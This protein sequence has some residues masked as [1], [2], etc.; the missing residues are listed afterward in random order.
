MMCAQHADQLDH[1]SAY[2]GQGES[3]KSKLAWMYIGH[4]AAA[5]T[6]LYAAIVCTMS[7][8]IQLTIELIKVKMAVGSG[9][10]SLI[11]LLSP[12]VQTHL[13]TCR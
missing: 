3:E 10:S 8:R 6:L 9:A 13:P 12:S 1:A 7:E 11:I 4:G 2:L 5:F